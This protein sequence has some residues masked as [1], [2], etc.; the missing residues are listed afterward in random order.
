VQP[1]W[2]SGAALLG[3]CN[4]LTKRYDETP[5]LLGLYEAG[6]TQSVRF[7]LLERATAAPPDTYLSPLL[8]LLGLKRQAHCGLQLADSQWPADPALLR[9]GFLPL[10]DNLW[11]FAACDAQ[12]PPWPAHLAPTAMEFCL[13][14][15]E[16]KTFLVP[17]S[18][19]ISLRAVRLRKNFEYARECYPLPEELAQRFAA[20]EDYLA[21][22]LHLSLGAQ[23][24][25]LLARFAPVCFACGLTAAQTMDGFLYH[26]ALRRLESADPVALRY[27]MKALQAMLTKTFGQHS[28]PLSIAYLMRTE[29]S[30]IN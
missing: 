26:K 23:C 16:E 10:P 4:A 9:E 11:L 5:F 20:L 1:D 17:W 8:P 18:E 27:E 29:T 15:L 24:G 25:E 2:Q 28:L 13:P 6:W 22:Q 19:P 3:Q 14:A 12:D 7:A 30:L 21:Q